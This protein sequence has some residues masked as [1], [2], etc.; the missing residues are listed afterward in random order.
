MKEPCCQSESIHLDSSIIFEQYLFKVISLI[1][2]TKYNET[3][4][5]EQRS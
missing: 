3:T 4:R 2:L 1:T 5:R